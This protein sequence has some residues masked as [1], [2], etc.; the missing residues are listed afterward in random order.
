[1]EIKT[2]TTP[3]MVIEQ[4]ELVSFL[5]SSGENWTKYY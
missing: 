2:Y 5:S 4:N 3:E 1:M